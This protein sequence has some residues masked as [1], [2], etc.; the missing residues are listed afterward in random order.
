MHCVCVC[1][2]PTLQPLWLCRW[3]RLG[4]EL[5]LLDAPGIIPAQFNDQIAAQRLAICNDIGEASY[6]DSL[7]A[8][9]MII[10][11][12]HLPRNKR[13][14]AKLQQRYKLDPLSVSAEEFVLHVA[15]EVFGGDREQAGVRL[16]GD[17][18]NGALGNFALELPWT[19]G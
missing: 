8:A 15:G 9:A 10:Q 6:V 7:I 3:V 12:K 17:Y 16:L 4:G 14:L 13:P 1:S 19:K 18:R 5:D 11:I 2:S